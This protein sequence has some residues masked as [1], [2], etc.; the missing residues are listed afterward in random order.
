MREELIQLILDCT[1]ELNE[2]DG[3]GIEGPLSEETRLFGADGI[4]DS[5]GLVSLVV[6]LEQ[7]I[8][9]RFG[10]TV[11]L[12]TEKALS[13]RNSPYRSVG[14]LADFAAAELAER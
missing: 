5:M 1:Q 7:A 11:G 2:S 3:L 6:A 10:K 9:D 12:A 13:M 14:T 8:Q 4:L